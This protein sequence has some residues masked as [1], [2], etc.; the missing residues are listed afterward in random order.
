MFDTHSNGLPTVRQTPKF[1][2]EDDF[3]WRCPVTSI[4]ENGGSVEQMREDAEGC[5]MHFEEGRTSTVRKELRPQYSHDEGHFRAFEC[6][7]A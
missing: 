4:R 2:A 1:G 3:R 5:E 7:V 6:F